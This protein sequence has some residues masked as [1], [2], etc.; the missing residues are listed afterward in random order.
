MRTASWIVDLGFNLHNIILQNK[1]A[2]SKYA[3]TQW[4]GREKGSVPSHFPGLSSKVNNSHF[5]FFFPFL[6]SFSFFFS[7]FCHPKPKTHSVRF[8]NFENTKIEK[9]LQL[10]FQTW[11]HYPHRGNKSYFLFWS[12]QGAGIWPAGTAKNMLA[13]CLDFHKKL[14][15]LGSLFSCTLI[16]FVYSYD[17][18]NFIASLQ[19]DRWE[20]GD[21]ILKCLPNIYIKFYPWVTL[22]LYVQGGTGGVSIYEKL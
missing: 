16:F 9:V 21:E 20:M 4:N 5:H 18:F 14:S 19:I 1:G 15:S 12:P 11:Y 7:F 6:F 17:N 2:R 10:Q 13:T 3:M 22:R 8:L